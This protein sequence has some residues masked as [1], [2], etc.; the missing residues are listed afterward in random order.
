MKK[1]LIFLTLFFGTPLAYSESASEPDVLYITNVRQTGPKFPFPS[2]DR[3][4][5]HSI[6]FH[7]RT[8][9]V[10]DNPGIREKFVRPK[11][12][13]HYV[14]TEAHQEG[15]QTNLL[16]YNCGSM[17]SLFFY[18]GIHQVSSSWLRG[19]LVDSSYCE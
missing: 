12:S 3:S 11:T 19:A 13:F 5:T 16:S 1:A 14:Y 8:V 6:L 17:C 7:L 2:P 4:F 9:E 15:N 10:K 18:N